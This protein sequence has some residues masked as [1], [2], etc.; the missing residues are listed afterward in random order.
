V[1]ENH[2]EKDRQTD[3]QTEKGMG[4]AGVLDSGQKRLQELGYKQELQ[5]DLSYVGGS[6]LN[7][8]STK[9]DL[10]LLIS[11]SQQP[12]QLQS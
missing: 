11:K 6:F 10:L 9:L 8:P 12:Q 1:L 7:A 3:R 5:R 2:R 4:I